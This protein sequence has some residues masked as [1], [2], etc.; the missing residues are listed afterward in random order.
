MSP[1]CFYQAR[2]GLAFVSA[3]G[4]ARLREYSRRQKVWLS[5]LLSSRQIRHFGADEG[6]G[7]YVTIAHADPMSLARHLKAAGV[8]GDARAYGLR[9][10]PDLL[11]TQDQLERA[12]DRLAALL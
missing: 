9:L 1:Q 4:V 7:A 5:A 11:N 10:C 2:A 8:N 12:V 3:I 6:Y